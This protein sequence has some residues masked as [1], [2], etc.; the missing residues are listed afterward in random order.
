MTIIEPVG[1][2]SD[3]CI[4]GHYREDHEPKCIVVEHSIECL[5]TSFIPDEEDD[6][7]YYDYHDNFTDEQSDKGGLSV[8]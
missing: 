3:I 2:A 7:G 4:C 6:I 8:I 1:I 5:C